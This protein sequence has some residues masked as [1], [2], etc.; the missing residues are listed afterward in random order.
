MK[1]ESDKS[2]T[3]LLDKITQTNKFKPEDNPNSTGLSPDLT[4]E[5]IDESINRL[6]K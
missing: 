1:K 3:E 6:S 2:V 5:D 4:D